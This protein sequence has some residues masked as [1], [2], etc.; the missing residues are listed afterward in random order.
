MKGHLLYSLC[1]IY[2]ISHSSY[3]VER[4]IRYEICC[5]K[6]SMTHQFLQTQEIFHGLKAHFLVF[7]LTT[8]LS[9]LQWVTSVWLSRYPVSTALSLSVWS[10]IRVVQKNLKELWQVGDKEQL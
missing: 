10:L 6:L 9:F 3:F 5:V 1:G 2:G 8:V 7:L 4:E